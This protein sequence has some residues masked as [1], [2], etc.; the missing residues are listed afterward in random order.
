MGNDVKELKEEV[1]YLRKR[2]QKYEL[3]TI[4]PQR[5]LSYFEAKEEED[6]V[7]ES[8]AYEHEKDVGR[9]NR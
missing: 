2:L 1:T 5:R 7:N 3:K 9:R 8:I 4:F 6:L